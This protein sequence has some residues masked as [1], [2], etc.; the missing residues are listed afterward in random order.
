MIVFNFYYAV[1]IFIMRSQVMEH[2]I[3]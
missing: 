1:L 3:W 2:S